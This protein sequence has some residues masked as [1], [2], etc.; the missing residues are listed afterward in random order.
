MGAT[1]CGGADGAGMYAL[2]GAGVISA[3]TG[4][5]VVLAPGAGGGGEYAPLWALEAG[6]PMAALGAMGGISSVSPVVVSAKFISATPYKQ[7]IQINT[8]RVSFVNGTIRG[9]MGS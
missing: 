1:G 6:A 2:K 7:K 4:G 8:T 5:G 9:K 3:P